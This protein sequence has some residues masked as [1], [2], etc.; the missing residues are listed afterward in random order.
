MNN[1]TW[2][3]VLLFLGVLFIKPF[4]LISQEVIIEKELPILQLTINVLLPARQL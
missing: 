1:Y 4:S 3:I 2:H